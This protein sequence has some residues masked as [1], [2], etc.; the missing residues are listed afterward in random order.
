MRGDFGVNMVAA[1]K[2]WKGFANWH[3]LVCKRDP[4]TAEERWVKE[5]NKLPKDDNKRVK[6]KK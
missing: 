6:N 5:G 1:P 4:L 2:D 3:K